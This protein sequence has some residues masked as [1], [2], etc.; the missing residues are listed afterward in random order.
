M[1]PNNQFRDWVFNGTTGLRPFNA[2]GLTLQQIIEFIRDNDYEPSVDDISDIVKLLSVHEIIELHET[3]QLHPRIHYNDISRHPVTLE[4]WKVIRCKVMDI[5]DKTFKP[6]WDITVM[7][8]HIDVSQIL[9]Y[10]QL[11][12]RRAAF[13]DNRSVTLEHADRLNIPMELRPQLM[14]RSPI[15][16]C[17]DI[18]TGDSCH[19][20]ARN[21][22]LLPEHVLELCRRFPVEVQRSGIEESFCYELARNMDPS[23]IVTTIVLLSS[24]DIDLSWRE[25]WMNKRLVPEIAE[26]LKI[27]LNEPHR[28][29]YCGCD[30]NHLKNFTAP[31]HNNPYI[32]SGQ[33]NDVLTTHPRSLDLITKLMSLPAHRS[34]I[35]SAVASYHN[36]EAL[37]EFDYSYDPDGVFDSILSRDDVT[38]D[39]IK[40]FTSRY[41]VDPQGGYWYPTIL[42][43]PEDLTEAVP[44]IHPFALCR[45]RWLQISKLITYPINP[46]PPER[47]LSP[48]ELEHLPE[49]DKYEL[50]YNPK[51]TYQDYMALVQ[52]GRITFDDIKENWDYICA[53]IPYSE[54]IKFGIHIDVDY[55]HH[56]TLTHGHVTLTRITIDELLTLFTERDIVYGPLDDVLTAPQLLQLGYPNMIDE[57]TPGMTLDIA[58]RLD[59]NPNECV[60]LP[61]QDICTRI[62]PDS[63]VTLEEAGIT[64]CLFHEI[65]ARLYHLCVMGEYTIIRNCFNPMS[66]TE[67]G[68]RTFLDIGI[69]CQW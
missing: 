14:D 43:K 21:P 58:S 25:V 67:R 11:G 50:R 24:H 10:P 3:L 23:R 40:K 65:D 55:M 45:C 51:M 36:I 22:E 37:M 6:C 13:L 33:L 68:M 41:H 62:Q 35:A 1:R 2:E 49:I 47:I 17:M 44:D 7:S 34:I 61:L 27:L 59:I 20:L 4:G 16:L 64:T 30:I 53:N 29:I 39:H 57:Y 42:V 52:S 19:I 54:A 46:V 60:N 9:E 32:S 12:W 63:Y 69:T 66:F 56:V 15:H 31:W 48:S 8:R 18:V 26:R 28:E 38:V 5:F